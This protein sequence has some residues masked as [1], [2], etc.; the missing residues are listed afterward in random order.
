MDEKESVTIGHLLPAYENSNQIKIK[1]HL[2]APVP[3]GAHPVKNLSDLKH[4]LEIS[5]HFRKYTPRLKP[6]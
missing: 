3:T 6:G 1:R 4:P 5:E 2:A